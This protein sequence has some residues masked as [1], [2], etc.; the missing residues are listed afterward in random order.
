MEYLNVESHGPTCFAQSCVK[1]IQNE[2][3]VNARAL[4]SEHGW[5]NWVWKLHPIEISSSATRLAKFSALG[6]FLNY[7]STLYFWATFSTIK[8]IH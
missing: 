4:G 5:L 3:I 2:E 7:I 6:S 1:K 8:V